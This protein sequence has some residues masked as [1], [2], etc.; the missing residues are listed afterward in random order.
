MPMPIVPRGVRKASELI[1]QQGRSI[2]ITEEDDSKLDWSQIPDGTLKVNPTTGLMSVKLEGETT[3]V[4]AGLR[5][6]GTICIAKDSKQNV[7]TFTI[8]T[9]DN[10]DGTFTY[11]NEN[12]DQR[13]QPI[14]G[15]L[16]M[17]ELEE[18]SYMCLRNMIEVTIDDIYTRS[19]ASGGLIEHDMQ[20]FYLSKED[21]AVDAEITARYITTFR[22]GSPYPRI[23]VGSNEPSDAE[24]GDFWLDIDATCGNVPHS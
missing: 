10:G 5:N 1:T 14:D 9:V 11:T 21:I 8:K 19:S 15:D 16:Y 3:W 2:I 13:H 7:E 6:D 24:V 17:F 20:R 12:G 18:G 4:P 23:F 22:W